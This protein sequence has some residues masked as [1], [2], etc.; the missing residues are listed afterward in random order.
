[1][2]LFPF[3]PSPFAKAAILYMDGVGE[4]AT[5]STWIGKNNKIKPIW[6]ISFLYSLGLLYSPLT[7]YCGFY[8]LIIMGLVPS[9]NNRFVQLTFIFLL[10]NLLKG[11]INIQILEILSS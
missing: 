5:K 6:Q 1:M 8:S 10:L 7:Y 4:C 3:Y 9:K 2:L 11:C